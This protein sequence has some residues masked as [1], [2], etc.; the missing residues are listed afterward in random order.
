MMPLYKN[1][2]QTTCYHRRVGWKIKLGSLDLKNQPHLKTSNNHFRKLKR[3]IFQL[4]K[5]L[6]W[7]KSTKVSRKK[8]LCQLQSTFFRKIKG[9]KHFNE[10]SIVKWNMFIPRTTCIVSGTGQTINLLS[11]CYFPVT[12]SS[13]PNSGVET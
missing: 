2:N 13:L 7:S 3:S 10:T 1:N 5:P 4:E 11:L 6:N 8:F 12:C 9:K